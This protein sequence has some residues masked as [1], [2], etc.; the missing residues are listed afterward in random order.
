MFLRSRLNQ[1]NLCISFRSSFLQC[2]EFYLFCSYFILFLFCSLLFHHLLP[3]AIYLLKV[4][5]RN[6]ITRCE[7]YSKSRKKTVERCHWH[8]FDIFIVNSEYISHLVLVF[9]LLTLK[10]ITG[11]GVSHDL[12]TDSY[13][14]NQR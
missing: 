1:L 3:A 9:L 12:K 11:W 6:T 2:L 10:I 14:D 5:N 4:N 13:F 7:I 8:L